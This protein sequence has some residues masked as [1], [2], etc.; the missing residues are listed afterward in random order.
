[1]IVKVPAQRKDGHSSF[2]K[3]GDYITA[4]IHQSKDSPYR[5]SFEKLTQYITKQSVLDVLGDQVEKTIA[6]EI[7]NLASLKTAPADMYAV[8]AH[9]KNVKNPVYHYILSWPENETPTVQ[10]IF[11]A[12]HHTLKALGMDEHQYIV[13]IH[14]NTD[15]LHAHIEVN[16]IN[17]VSYKA[18]TLE[19][20]HSKLHK[21]AR[22]VEIE[23]GW[24]HDNGI[25]NVIEIE[26]NKRI[27][28]NDDYV[29]PDLV[30]AKGAANTFEVWS[31][32]QSLETWC[33]NAPT[34]ALKDLLANA[35]VN[36]WQQLHQVLAD[37]GLEL[38]YSGGGGMRVFDTGSDSPEKKGKP[39]VVSASKAFRFLKLKDLEQRFGAFVPPILNDKPET[40]G[41][42]DSGRN[43]IA[44]IERN[45]GKASS[46]LREIRPI[47]PANEH[48]IR[49]HFEN[50]ADAY[51]S[52]GQGYGQG[53]HGG[54][55]SD[56]DN[57]EQIN[58]SEYFADIAN[59]LAAAG[60]SLKKNGRFNRDFEETASANRAA[61]ANDPRSIEQQYPSFETDSRGN[62]G[63]ARTG[64]T[65]PITSYKRDPYKRL[66]RRLARKEIRDKLFEKFKNAKTLRKQEHQLIKKRLRE[67]FSTD[68]KAR[69]AALNE[70]R[71]SMRQDILHNRSMSVL[72]RKQAYSLLSMTMLRA[73]EQLK[74][75]ISK[76]RQE[77]E[78]MMPV[79]FTWREWVEQQAQ[80]GDEAAI[81]ALRGIIYQE[82]RESKK[83]TINNS[84]PSIQPERFQ[85][86]DPTVRKFSDIQWR[87]TRTGKVIYS[88]TNN[89]PIF[90]DNGNKLTFDR[91]EVSDEAL[92]V[93]LQYAKE[94]WGSNLTL[95][96]GDAVFQERLARMAT[97]L[98]ITIT[99]PE[100]RALQAK[101]IERV[102]PIPVTKEFET[103]NNLVLA[104][105]PNARI[106]GISSKN[107][108]YT[109]PIV[110]QND[111]HVIQHLGKNDY[112]L[113]D[114][115]NVTGAWP[116]NNKPV[117]IRYKSGIGVIAA[118]KS[119]SKDK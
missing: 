30:K 17:P 92:R 26:G 6:V 63:R 111:T 5:H 37:F 67:T 119:I 25:W 9:N 107:K 58:E 105:N 74:E 49:T 35:D 41:S 70:K 110:A 43:D 1:M 38:K 21:A 73:K 33:R 89:D 118:K 55:G 84:K 32:E 85:D 88:F 109:G 95:A 116:S 100:I 97:E 98:N 18:V 31:G 47:D 114:K 50:L 44:D 82:K 71:R 24:Q 16:R 93:T 75:Q 23:Y 108:N 40:G 72:E 7:G 22:E 99:N 53:E 13:A 27:I 42:N 91:K 113:H 56:F 86:T 39:L 90:A 94:K 3:L 96:G 4:G 45:L 76:E 12:A 54:S 66:D 87:V 112:V 106:E 104:N 14:S 28:R 20:D 59:N 103:L 51:P 115:T 46:V 78:G 62:P 102:V 10:D 36:S 19:W 65:K 101:H 79:L 81:S 68:E 57:G 48:T 117:V 80:L 64:N 69:Y 2:K 11:G 52:L 77:R 8:A 61:F 15:N 34:K 60:R 29:D 83:E